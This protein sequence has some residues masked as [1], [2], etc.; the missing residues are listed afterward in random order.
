MFAVK[1]S[2]EVYHCHLLPEI[3]FEL[4]IE[5]VTS[6]DVEQRTGKQDTVP[7]SIQLVTSADQSQGSTKL[8]AGP[9]D[10]S[11]SAIQ[12]IIVNHTHPD[13]DL[14]NFRRDLHEF[15]RLRWRRVQTD[16]D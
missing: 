5:W 4:A 8:H 16:I 12:D 3:R 9:K 14:A 10:N 7:F 13:D 15:C 11:W 6:P 1:L 2:S